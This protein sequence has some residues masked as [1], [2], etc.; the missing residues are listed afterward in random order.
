MGSVAR[1]VLIEPHRHV[2]VGLCVSSLA[3]DRLQSGAASKINCIRPRLHAGS[4]EGMGLRMSESGAPALC[5][6]MYAFALRRQGQ[7]LLLQAGPAC[8]ASGCAAPRHTGTA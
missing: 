5:M 7:V 4:R 1:L 8:T 3:K 2:Q 6:P